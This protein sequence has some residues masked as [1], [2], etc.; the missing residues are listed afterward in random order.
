M[1][2]SWGI[3]GFETFFAERKRLSGSTGYSD[4]FW[5]AWPLM[6]SVVNRISFAGLCSSI[7]GPIEG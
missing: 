3:N 5:D 7:L 1:D 2:T 6:C 4:L